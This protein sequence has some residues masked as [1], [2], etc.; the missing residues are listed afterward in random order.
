MIRALSLAAAAVAVATPALAHPGH[1]APLFHAHATDI[2]LV[3]LALLVVSFGLG[4]A[5]K[6]LLA[7]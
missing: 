6:R 3:G 2:A 4:R 1:G 7:R 5:V